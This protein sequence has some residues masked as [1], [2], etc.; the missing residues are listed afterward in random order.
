MIDRSQS[1]I[2]R[3]IGPSE[4]IKNVIEE[5]NRKNCDLR[6]S[7]VTEKEI[8]VDKNPE[9]GILFCTLV[10]QYYRAIHNPFVI[11]TLK[12]MPID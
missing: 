10:D 11:V 4:F 2:V 5:C 9:V 3:L 6:I 12:N 8:E 1:C 7:T